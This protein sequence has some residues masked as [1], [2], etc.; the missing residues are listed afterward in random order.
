MLYAININRNTFTRHKKKGV[1]RDIEFTP[2]PTENR[3]TTSRNAP[4]G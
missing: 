2:M 1:E 3:A 4:I